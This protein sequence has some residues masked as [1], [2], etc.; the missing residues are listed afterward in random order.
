MPDS[1]GPAAPAPL[2]PLAAWR[3]SQDDDGCWFIRRG[4]VPDSYLYGFVTEAEAIIV[5]DALN[6]ALSGANEE[7]PQ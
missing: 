5:R 4:S 7:T 1:P 2:D 3:I 6:A